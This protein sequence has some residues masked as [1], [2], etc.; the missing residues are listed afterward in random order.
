M[1]LD[2]FFESLGWTQSLN[3]YLRILF[4]TCVHRH[5][6]C[7][8]PGEQ[9]TQETTTIEARLWVSRDETGMVDQQHPCRNDMAS[10]RAQPRYCLS[11]PTAIRLSE[12]LRSD[13]LTIFCV[14]SRIRAGADVYLRQVE[15]GQPSRTG[16][17]L[18][19]RL[20]NS[21]HVGLL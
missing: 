19:A 10:R 5:K 15:V 14:N 3:T 16:A 4:S 18:P 21:S 20:G 9:N 11:E 8:P 1:R 7:L 13:V 12:Q 6:L 2:R 17:A